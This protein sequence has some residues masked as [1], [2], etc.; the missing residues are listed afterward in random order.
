MDALRRDEPWFDELFTPG[1]EAETRRRRFMEA[2]YVSAGIPLRIVEV[3]GS[4][5]DIVLM[6]PRCLHTVSA[7]HSRRA[8]LQMR[9]TCRQVY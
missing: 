5:G 8:R 3:T 9:L 1:S 7:N 4:A 2:E 6:D